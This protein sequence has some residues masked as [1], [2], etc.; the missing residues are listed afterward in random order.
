MQGIR[1]SRP[2]ISDM[3]EEVLQHKEKKSVVKTRVE[4]TRQQRSVEE[5]KRLANMKNVEWSKSK[6]SLFWIISR[7][8]Q[9]NLME[10]LGS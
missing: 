9:R 5:K 1:V 2:K 10:H 6:V 3:L 8:L 4:V 7:V